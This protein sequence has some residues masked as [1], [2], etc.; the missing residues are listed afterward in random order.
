MIEELLKLES[1]AIRRCAVIIAALGQKKGIKRIS[2]NNLHSAIYLPLFQTL[3]ESWLE[4]VDYSWKD[5]S[6]YILESA[7]EKPEGA[8]S[9]ARGLYSGCLLHILTERNREKKR[10]TAF[11]FEGEGKNFDYLFSFA[12]EVDTL[13]IKNCR[14]DGIAGY[15]GSYEGHLDQLLLT[16]NK[17]NALANG[18]GSYG[19]H[20]GTVLAGNNQGDWTAGWAGSESGY[21]DAVLVVGNQGANAAIHAGSYQGHAGTVLVV[22]N[23][24]DSAA[25]SIGSEKGYAG[26]VLVLNNRGDFPANNVAAE[27]TVEL[28][29]IVNSIGIGA[30]GWSLGNGGS[31]DTIVAAKNEGMAVADVPFNMALSGKGLGSRNIRRLILHDLDAVMLAMAKRYKGCAEQHIIGDRAAAKE[32]QALARKY[33][34]SELQQFADARDYAA[35]IRTIQQIKQGQQPLLFPGLGKAVA[36]VKKWV[37]N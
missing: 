34:I 23:K 32:Y 7:K 17:G 13:H 4:S 1:T 29:M 3:R 12:Q 18:A 27:G 33:E 15:L 19:G 5:L 28:M 21:V 31:I 14:G 36:T 22:N 25:E 20:A 24:G 8:E 26:V 10:E 37:E 6:D 35:V 30:A 16:G 2:P 11:S 9:L